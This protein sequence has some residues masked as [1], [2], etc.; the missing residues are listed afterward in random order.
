MFG[1]TGLGY[2]CDANFLSHWNKA[3]KYIQKN[4]LFYCN[5]LNTFSFMHDLSYI[6]AP[7]YLRIEKNVKKTLS[8]DS[9][10]SEENTI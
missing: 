4:L 3:R 5:L 8:S 10:H 9:M 6:R 7:F 2:K 1:L